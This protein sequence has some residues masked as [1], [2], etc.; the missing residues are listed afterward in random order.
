MSVASIALVFAQFDLIMI[1]LVVDLFVNQYTIR[2]FLANKTHD[3]YRYHTEYLNE[4]ETEFLGG[5]SEDKCD[6]HQMHLVGMVCARVF[7]E[8]YSRPGDAPDAVPV[9]IDNEDVECIME[10]CAVFL[11]HFYSPDE[12]ANPGDGA[13][14][15]TAPVTVM[16]PTDRVSLQQ[17]RDLVH[18][19][20][21]QWPLLQRAMENCDTP[22]AKKLLLERVERLITQIFIW[23]G[24]YLFDNDIQPC[25]ADD[26]EFVHNVPPTHALVLTDMGIKFFLNIFFVLFRLLF[27]QRYAVPVPA[28]KDKTSGAYPFTVEGFHMEA[29]V[30][31]FHMLGMYFDIPAGC[32]LEYKHSYSGYYNNVSQCVYRHFP[33]YKRRLPV[34]MVDIEFDDA[35]D[36]SVLPALKQIYPE[37]EFAFEDHHFQREVGNLRKALEAWLNDEEWFAHANRLARLDRAPQIQDTNA[38]HECNRRDEV[39]S[40]DMR[41]F[42]EEYA[43]GEAAHTWFYEKDFREEAV[44]EYRCER[45][46]LAG[47]ELQE[48]HR[49]AGAAKT[50][51]KLQRQA[52]AAEKAAVRAAKEQTNRV[53]R[54]EFVAFARTT[55]LTAE[56]DRRASGAAHRKRTVAYA[57]TPDEVEER[58]QMQAGAVKPREYYERILN[59]ANMQNLYGVKGAFDQISLPGMLELRK[60]RE[61]VVVQARGAYTAANPLSVCFPGHDIAPTRDLFE[62]MLRT[63]I[64]SD[65]DSL[66]NFTAWVSTKGTQDIAPR[67]LKYPSMLCAKESPIALREICYLVRLLYI[68]NVPEG[69]TSGTV[70]DAHIKLFAEYIRNMQKSADFAT[71]LGSM[72]EYPNL[73]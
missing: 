51:D 48:V 68:D 62:R 31:D 33:S 25:Q 57:E 14:T 24:A 52:D 26:T 63:I 30:D 34:T 29:G 27:L 46:C 2:R 10:Q 3:P 13:D 19:I 58:L 32:L 36:L 72:D 64:A 11:P 61:V 60:Q 54:D 66:I 69:R 20:Q 15:A 28:G 1:R 40:A 12:T 21:T 22:D 8:A 4:D 18:A 39:A 44:H 37:I 5:D 67:G 71:A 45:A 56:L 70:I 73:F 59:R 49:E 43:A 9:T 7:M 41:R 35:A 50:A 47:N 42:M 23:F 65:T 38:T 55:Y 16:V 17:L 6:F 53:Q